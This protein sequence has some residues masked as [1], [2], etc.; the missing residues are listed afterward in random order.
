MVSAA[1]VDTSERGKRKRQIAG[2][3]GSLFLGIH[4]AFSQTVSTT[5]P[6]SA[7][8]R[9]A[10]A[11][12]LFQGDPTSPASIGIP[13]LATL[14]P[15]LPDLRT[16]VKRS[17][18]FVNPSHRHSGA[19]SRSQVAAAM[20]PG[21]MFRRCEIRRARRRATSVRQGSAR[22]TPSPNHGPG[23][24]FPPHSARARSSRPLGSF[25]AEPTRRGSFDTRSANL[26]RFLGRRCPARCWP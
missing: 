15:R 22:G 9:L 23:S 21:L 19:T 14:V 17:P 18:D 3:D 12:R 1:V 16:P 6:L 7:A 11:Q 25:F 24:S 26:R 2:E 13:T 8:H 20:S 4:I 5:S 10:F